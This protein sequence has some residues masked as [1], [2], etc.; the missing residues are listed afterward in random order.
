MCV[1]KMPGEMRRKVA[2]IEEIRRRNM[3]EEAEK[4]P[5]ERRNEKKE[6]RRNKT[7]FITLSPA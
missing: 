4:K 3:R 2:R 5:N 6:K 1:T 7:H